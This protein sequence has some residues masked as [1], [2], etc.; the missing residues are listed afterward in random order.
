MSKMLVVATALAAVVGMYGSAQAAGNPAAGKTKAAACAACHGADGNAVAPNFPKLAG[1]HAGY[2]AKQL[3]DYKS[4]ARQDP[5]MS[6]MAQ[7][8]SEED[9]QDLAAYYASQ[10]LTLGNADESLVEVGGRIWRGGNPATGVAA[11]TACH[12]PAGSGNAPAVFPLLR[13]QHAQ[14]TAAQ[15]EKFRAA[16]RIDPNAVQAGA[17]LPGRHNDPGRMMQNTARGMTDYEIRAVA[18]YLQGLRP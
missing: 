1:Q 12:G 18:S 11:C 13:G 9:I 6:P 5:T 16:G 4:G 7:P 10:E 14:Y 3:Q 15:L 17:E 8:L 2:L